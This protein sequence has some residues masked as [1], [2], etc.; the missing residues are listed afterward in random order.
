VANWHL[1]VPYDEWATEW[2]AAHGYRHPP[3]QSG[4]RLP[5]D[6]EIEEAVQELGIT[7]NAPLYIDGVGVGDS[8]NIR[9][10]L[11]LELRLLRRLAERVG[12]MWVYPDSGSP[13]IVV[14]PTIDPEAVA[15]AWLRSESADD[16]WTEFLGKLSDA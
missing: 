1:I 11:V 9:G 14:D 10:D 15:A 16:S 8:F 5:T 2:L 13:A 4:N 12:Q 6:S 7:S 3:V